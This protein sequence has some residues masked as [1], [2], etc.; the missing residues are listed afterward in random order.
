MIKSSADDGSLKKLYSTAKRSIDQF[1]M[2][3]IQRKQNSNVEPK[4]LSI[5]KSYKKIIADIWLQNV[6]KLVFSDPTSTY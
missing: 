2:H 4:L 5:W 3:V 6:K 1:L